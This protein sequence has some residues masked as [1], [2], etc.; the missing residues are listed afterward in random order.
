VRKW[1][2][3]KQVSQMRVIE[4]PKV[5]LALPFDEGESNIAGTQEFW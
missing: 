3:E 2:K 5:S 4:I 1:P